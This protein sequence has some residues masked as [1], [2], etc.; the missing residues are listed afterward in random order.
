MSRAKAIFLILGIAALAYLVERI[1]VTSIVT[2]LR[3]LRWWQFVLVCL[4]Y[5]IIMMVDTLGWRFAFARD[6]A[7][8][9][10]LVGARLAGEALNIVTA[11]GSVGGEA[12]KA[13]LASRDVSEEESIASVVIAKTTNVAAQ[14]LFLFIGILVAWATLPIDADM[15]SGMM[16][17]LVIEVLAV[18]GFFGVQM[19]GIVGRGGRLLVRFGVIDD[20]LAA[21]KL[22]AVLRGYYRHEWRRL[23]LSV[24]FHLLGWILGIGEAI[25]IL[26]ALGVGPDPLLA[27]VIETFGAGVRF[28]TFFIPASVGAFEGANA[29]AFKA[30]GIGAGLGLAF[31][32][33]RRA[34]QLVWIMIGIV[35]LIVMRPDAK[36]VPASTRRAA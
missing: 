7:P 25:V 31:S 21:G 17:M 3:Q 12:V 16:S 19:G 24:G 36:A 11:V 29:A 8:F 9:F 26:W 22:D 34:R 4:P 1:G 10:R 35:L 13:W 27:T 6:R 20:A 30:L 14:A 28:A 5:A 33:A 23:S 32:L 18:A 2:S 15:L